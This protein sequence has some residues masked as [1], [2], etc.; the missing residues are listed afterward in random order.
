MIECKSMIK[1][2]GSNV[3]GLDE[4]NLSIEDGEFVSVIGLSGAGKS[5]LLR[6]MN[7]LIDLTEGEIVIDGESL[8]KASK[9]KLR[10]IRRHIGMISQQFNLVKRSTVQK[11]VLSGRLGYY[12]TWKS[13]LGI[14]S[15]E[16]Y[17]KVEDALK[18]VG[19]SDKLQTRCDQL[20][21]G[22]QQR[23]SIAR[24]IVQGANILLADEPVSALDPITT[25]IILKDLQKV[26][27]ELKTTI[28]INLHDVEL[29]RQ[30]STRII[31]MRDGQIVFDGTPE[32][33]TDEKLVEIYGEEILKAMG[34]TV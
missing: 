29:A 18:R 14:F 9:K 16:D 21:G 23:V 2:Y 3:R 25:H 33:A 26:N 24:A 12:S 11:N 19:L 31:G 10:K 8:T 15:K 32:E 30:Y 17:H 22:Q 1:D 7:R 34:E 5:T 6:A 28:L 27:K 20:S 4:V 13:I